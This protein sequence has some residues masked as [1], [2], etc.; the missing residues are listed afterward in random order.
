[1]NFI[2]MLIVFMYNSLYEQIG[3]FFSV[4]KLQYEM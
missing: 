2:E 3:F 1:M 4:S